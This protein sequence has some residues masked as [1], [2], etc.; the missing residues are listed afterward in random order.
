MAK[1]DAPIP[2]CKNCLMTDWERYEAGGNVTTTYRL[3]LK[4]VW[5]AM[6]VSYGP[7]DTSF[8]CRNCGELLASEKKA[9]V[10]RALPVDHM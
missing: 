9:T 8:C 10:L 2:W 6:D 1:N 4:N 5:R 7:S 3:D